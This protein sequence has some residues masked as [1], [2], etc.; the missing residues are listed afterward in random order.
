M[1]VDKK[2]NNPDGKYA[3]SN[4]CKEI[5]SAITDN[6]GECFFD[7]EKLIVSKKHNY[8]VA[9]KESWGLEQFYPCGGSQLTYIDV[10][11]NNDK[12]LIDVGEA[13]LAIHYNNLFS[14]SQQYD[15]LIVNFA[16]IEYI[17][18]KGNFFPGDQ[19][20]FGAIYFYGCNGFPFPSTY[21]VP[22]QKFKSQ[23]LKRIIRKRKMGIV[24]TSIDTVKVYPNQTTTFSINW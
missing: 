2:G 7:R 6:N 15:S 24:T 19:N 21:T 12:V 9:V 22:T 1:L 14:P 20:I 3:G 23:R 10:G 5:S 18:T 13:D 4:D 11:N 8:F 16:T 17:D